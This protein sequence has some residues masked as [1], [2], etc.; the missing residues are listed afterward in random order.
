MIEPSLRELSQYDD[1]CA[2][3]EVMTLNYDRS[4]E[5]FLG[6]AVMYDWGRDFEEAH[7]IVEK[8]MWFSPLHGDVGALSETPFGC[9]RVASETRA[10]TTALPRLRLIEDPINH[11][12]AQHWIS[13]SSRVWFLCLGFHQKTWTSRYPAKKTNACWQAREIAGDA[14]QRRAEP[15]CGG[16]VPLSP[17]SKGRRISRTPS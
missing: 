6:D 11:T 12:T 2:D 10:I 4:F 14:S 16:G 9:G 1:G 8:R 5:N 13:K 17:G 15:R 3:V 7:Y